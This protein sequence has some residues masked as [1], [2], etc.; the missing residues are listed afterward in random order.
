MC[1]AET[2]L[3]VLAAEGLMSGVQCR[4]RRRSWRDRDSII[5]ASVGHDNT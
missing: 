1:A 2:V 4:D 3:L 5:G